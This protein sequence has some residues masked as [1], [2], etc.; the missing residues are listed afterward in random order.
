MKRELELNYC[1]CEGFAKDGDQ[2]YIG[3][4]TSAFDEISKNFYGKDKFDIYNLLSDRVKYMDMCDLT[5][6]FKRIHYQH[7]KR[8]IMLNFKLDG[9]EFD[10]TKLSK[11]FNIDPKCFQEKPN[12]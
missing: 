8:P 11:I 4:T 2:K 10:F 1:P 3:L 7:M 12:L 5:H 9:L 6:L